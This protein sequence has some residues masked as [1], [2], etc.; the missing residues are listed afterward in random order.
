MDTEHY[1]WPPLPD[2]PRIE[3]LDAIAAS[4][5]LDKSP[6]QRFWRAIVGEDAPISLAKPVEVKSDVA[7][8]KFFVSDLGAARLYVFD[9]PDMNCV[10]LPLAG[11]AASPIVYPLSLA[12]DQV[13]NLYVLERRYNNVL[14]FGPDE[15]F[16]SL[17]QSSKVYG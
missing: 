3:W 15:K 17:V 13:N 10:I 1:Y 16:L 2:Q 9:L 12:L 4:L 5:I 11:R 14:V 7:Q 6:T 8:N